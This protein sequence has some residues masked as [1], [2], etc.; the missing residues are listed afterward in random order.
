M[1]DFNEFVQLELPKRPFVSS[2]GVP[3]QIL[4]RSNNPQAIRE[5]IWSNILNDI[6]DQ[7]GSLNPDIV[8][9]SDGAGGM[10]SSTITTTELAMLAGVVDN[11][12][13]QL[14]NRALL[15]HDHNTSDIIG[16]DGVDG[17]D[18]ASVFI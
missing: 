6:Q 2:D 18:S 8:V 12:Q 1:A 11:I 5:L 10:T 17:G 4:V 16:W 9:V 15:G 3:G 14:S 7:I 13:V